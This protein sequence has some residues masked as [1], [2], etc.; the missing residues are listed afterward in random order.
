MEKNYRAEITGVFGDPVEG[1]PTGVME[2][3]AYE[4]MGLNF[5]YKMKRL[6]AGSIILSFVIVF[7]FGNIVN[8]PAESGNAGPDEKPDAFAQFS[9]N[10]S[11]RYF[12][13]ESDDLIVLDLI[14]AFGRLFASVGL[15]MNRES[16]YSYYAAEILPLCPAENENCPYDHSGLS[17]DVYIRLF[18]NMSY[19]GNYW[20][21]Q[22][23]QRLTLVPD[24]VM[25]SY[26]FGGG[27]ALVSKN[28]TLMNRS[29]NA[30]S[31]F[32]YG[33]A[34]VKS[35]YGT[36]SQ[37][38]VPEYL[39]GTRKAE[40]QNENE[41][42]AVQFSLDA[43]GTIMMLRESNFD[44]PPLLLK[45]G[46]SISEAENDA[47]ELCYLMSSPSSGTMPYRGCVLLKQEGDRISVEQNSD[48]GD[49]L[50]LPLNAGKYF[51]ERE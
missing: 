11:G 47:F 9:S 2:E 21:G 1:N 43:D 20:P 34:E 26:Y 7:L 29:G 5:R 17:F 28:N 51:Y 19:A 27:D 36:G 22:T 31:L 33:P 25:L 45:G 41:T 50:F 10:I 30:P 32:P 35:M 3:A 37:I 4:A 13:V 6:S 14:P 44:Y 23:F 24:G 15:Y 18:S 38:D 40:W 42:I 39:T 16:L 46:F 49:E 48:W 12:T 8:V